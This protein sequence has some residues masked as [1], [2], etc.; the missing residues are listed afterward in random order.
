MASSRMY[1]FLNRTIE[2]VCEEAGKSRQACALGMIKDGFPPPLSSS[3]RGRFHK[4]TMS[5]PVP[6][7]FSQ[8]RAEIRVDPPKVRSDRGSAIGS[9]FSL[10]DI[11]PALLMCSKLVKPISSH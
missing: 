11:E 7:Q 3:F 8:P 9:L 6:P 1:S 10:S 4:Q 2:R 5:H